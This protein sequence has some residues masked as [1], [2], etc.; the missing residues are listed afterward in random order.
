MKSRRQLESWFPVEKRQNV[1]NMCVIE[2]K[3]F[4]DLRLFDVWNN[5]LLDFF[6][7]NFSQMLCFFVQIFAF[8]LEF[9]PTEI[10]ADFFFT[11]LG[12]R[13]T[14][15]N[16]KTFYC[17][18]DTEVNWIDYN[19][20]QMILLIWPIAFNNSLF[21]LA[22]VTFIWARWCLTFFQG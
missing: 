22:P 7:T 12:M 1:R 9:Q 11:D 16:P 8:W 3:R 13:S 20:V 17:F 10:T 5:D 6:P 4:M 15:G 19:E 14:S 21:L 2:I 18:L